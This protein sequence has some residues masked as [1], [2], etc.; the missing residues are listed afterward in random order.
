MRL[1]PR[2]SDTGDPDAP[3]SL[4][5]S[6]SLEHMSL[7]TVLLPVCKNESLS[8][9]EEV[10]ALLVE[11]TEF[12]TPITSHK[13]QELLKQLANQLELGQEQEELAAL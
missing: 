8:H 4:Y 10:S 1:T 5:S 7:H 2:L 9:S 3:D 12:L 13:H 11:Q 6:S